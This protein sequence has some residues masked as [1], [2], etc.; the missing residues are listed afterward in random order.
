[1]R[2]ID[3]DLSENLTTLVGAFAAQ[4]AGDYQKALEYHLA[5]H[6]ASSCRVL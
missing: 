2:N 4:G 6:P 3:Q 1:M 5:A